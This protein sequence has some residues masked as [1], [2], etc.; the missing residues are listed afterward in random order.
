MKPRGR[1]RPAKEP[2]DLITIDTAI[3]E[4]KEFLT[5]KYSPTVAMALCYAKGTIYN[6]LYRKEI[7]GYRKGKYTLVSQREILKLVS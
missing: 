2:D 5:K 1:G 7:Q 6:K 3:E 4:I